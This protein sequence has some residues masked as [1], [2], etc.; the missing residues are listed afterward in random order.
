MFSLSF[1][2]CTSQNIM[3]IV[4]TPIRLSVDSALSASAQKSTVARLSSAHNPC[5]VAAETSRKPQNQNSVQVKI[6][7]DGKSNQN[8]QGVNGNVPVPH[9]SCLVPEPKMI[10]LNPWFLIV[11]KYKMIFGSQMMLN[12]WDLMH[13]RCDAYQ[14]RIRTGT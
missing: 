7:T 10:L 8:K 9:T 5:I 4:F 3:I 13:V 12:P 14:V 1:F 11:R 6:N 2:V